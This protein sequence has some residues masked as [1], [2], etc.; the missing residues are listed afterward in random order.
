V[1]NGAV[2]VMVL[3]LAGIVPAGARAQS[4]Q[5]GT[6]N[7]DPDAGVVGPIGFNI[8]AALSLP[9]SDSSDLADPGGGIVA[10]LTYRPHPMFG[11]RAEY[12]YSF[13]GLQE[14]LFGASDLD[15][16]HTMQYGV[17]N[18][19]LRPIKTRGFGFYVTGGAGI[20]Y[21]KVEIT[22]LN[23]VASQ[24]FCDPWAFVCFPEDV[25]VAQVLAARSS[26][27]FGINGGVGAYLMLGQSPMRVY[28][29]AR[30]H[31]IFGPDFKDPSGEARAANGQY[32]PIVLGLAF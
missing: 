6:N 15:G 28:L 14:K 21:R 20:Y 8:G 16:S 4:T 18:L 17:L 32:I 31:F 23:G 30:Y 19:V 22:R 3:A 1:K 24:P 29:E 12:M 5:Y 26:T 10:G 9:I 13:Y 2:V 27:D 25:A 7:A 11:I